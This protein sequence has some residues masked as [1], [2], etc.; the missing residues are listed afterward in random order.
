MTLC[1]LTLVHI[2]D[3]KAQLDA[4][5]E[6]IRSIAGAKNCEMSVL[7]YQQEDGLNTVL[8]YGLRKIDTLRTLTTESAAALV[9][10]FFSGN[11]AQRRHLLRR[12]RDQP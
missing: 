6:T 7:T 2:A 5:T 10:V 12:Q 1:V 8:P 9:P 3:D 4:D 11:Q